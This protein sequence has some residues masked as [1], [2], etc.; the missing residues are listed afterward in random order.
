MNGY[1]FR[2]LPNYPGHL[3]HHPV[4]L[5]EEDCVHGGQ[6]GLLAG[7]D[8][9]CDEALAGLGL[10]L[11]VGVRGRHHHLAAPVGRQSGVEP[12]SAELPQ[13]VRLADILAVDLTRVHKG[14]VLVELLPGSEPLLAGQGP[15]E[16][17]AV[18]SARGDVQ[19]GEVWV[20][21]G[22][23]DGPTLGVHR[24]RGVTSPDIRERG[25]SWS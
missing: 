22:H 16:G 6:S 17:D 12:T 10:A 1:I 25:E 13:A 15:R 23:G 5:T 24:L 21:A 4:V 19:G 11:L 14:R 3:V 20:I 7:S 8:V 18:R 9:S 2:N